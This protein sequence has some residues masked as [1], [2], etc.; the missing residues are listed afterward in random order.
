MNERIV[1]TVIGHSEQIVTS[2]KEACV[3]VKLGLET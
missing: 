1:C 2:F 3:V